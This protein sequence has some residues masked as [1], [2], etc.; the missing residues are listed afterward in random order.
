MSPAPFDFRWTGRLALCI[1][2]FLIIVTTSSHSFSQTA[3]ESSPLSQ[4]RVVEGLHIQMQIQPLDGST[5]LN[6][7]A[8]A[9]V[10]FTLRDANSMEPLTG[11]HPLGWIHQRKGKFPPNETMLDDMVSRFLGGILSVTADH[12]LNRYY[13]VVLNDDRSISIIDPL[14]AFS[15]TKLRNLIGLPGDPV[16]WAL[17]ELH[18]RLLVTI[19][20][21]GKLVVI[22]LTQA[23]IEREIEFGDDTDPVK[24]LIQN[25]QSAAWIS[26]DGTDELVR[27]DL[28]TLDVGPRIA[29]GKGRHTTAVDTDSRWLVATNTSD[30]TVT[31]IDIQDD[32]LPSNTL[33][34]GE[35]PIAIKYAP[36]A[37]RFLV[38]CANENR[39]R[40]IDP[41][42]SQLTRSLEIPRGVID[43]SVEP[44]GRFA[45]LTSPSASVVAILD[46][47]SKELVGT[48][49][50]AKAPDRVVCTSSF[51][52]IHDTE[53]A[54][55]ILVDLNRLARGELVVTELGIGRQSMA[56]VAAGRQITSLLAPAPEG[57]SM[58]VGNSA[59]KLIYY[60][61]EGMM[62][63]M[64]NFQTY[65]RIP[66]GVLVLD[67]S[68]RETGPGEYSTFVRFNKHGKF[69]LPLLI[70]QPRALAHFEI[71]VIRDET[72]P[73]IATV[74]PVSVDFLPPEDL[75]RAGQT[76]PLQISITD[77][78]TKEPVDGLEDVHVM[79][80]PLNGAFQFR[81]LAEGVG[82]GVYQV[83]GSFPE[84]LRFGLLVQVAS[85]GLTFKN[86][87]LHQIGVHPAEAQK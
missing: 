76:V 36:L 5:V 35:T 73:L 18:E 87:Q 34:V 62:A 79:L 11:L 44:D 71:D 16:D 14:V 49:T 41:A 57:N 51:A 45:F 3:Q 43:V 68:L 75:I 56:D 32:E 52:Y 50:T 10:T 77:S 22:D 8:D 7:G 86:S 72:I 17:S 85:R 2:A 42:R 40:L 53:R 46:T 54:N 24:V 47:S 29:L 12:D 70:D 6:Q 25:D 23:K 1:G 28:E 81:L 33:A 58:F 82:N 60:Y 65:K 15:I 4:Q 74:V 83:Q 67:R 78:Q 31:I 63:A 30:G 20:D 84:Q 27:I 21:Q 69:D 64:G 66:R 55:I 80:F 37:A 38:A 61:V 26:L 13:L 39:L 48:I 19:P 59:D 9:R